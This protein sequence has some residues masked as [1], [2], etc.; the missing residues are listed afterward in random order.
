MVLIGFSVTGGHAY[1][2]GETPREHL[3]GDSRFLAIAGGLDCR[4]ST[5][6]HHLHER[7]GLDLVF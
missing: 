3:G 6:V 2:E 1:L 5:T 7:Y 4:V